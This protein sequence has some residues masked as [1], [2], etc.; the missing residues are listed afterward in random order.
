M[1]DANTAS[2]EV[3]FVQVTLSVNHTLYISIKIMLPFQLLCTPKH[4]RNFLNQPTIWQISSVW[5]FIEYLKS[6]ELWIMWNAVHPEGVNQLESFT[7]TITGVEYT[8]TKERKQEK[9][10]H[11]HHYK[12]CMYTSGGHIILTTSDFTDPKWLSQD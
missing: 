2:W 11:L 6:S 7:F 5:I 3:K 4:L 12:N 10:I 8:R 9:S 1:K